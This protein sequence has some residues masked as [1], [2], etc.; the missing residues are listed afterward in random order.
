ML[1]GPHGA[2]PVLPGIVRPELT[3]VLHAGKIEALHAGRFRPKCLTRNCRW[4]LLGL[5][6][7]D[8]LWDPENVRVEFTR[9]ILL[10]LFRH[11]VQHRIRPSVK[12]SLPVMDSA[13]VRVV[14]ELPT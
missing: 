3:P 9:T 13:C 1:F 8:R 14:K 6:D 4:G 7:D 12:L 10:V 2:A 11:F 5:Y